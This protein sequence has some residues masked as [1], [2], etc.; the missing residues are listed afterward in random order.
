MERRRDQCIT[1][2]AL[3]R[4]HQPVFRTIMQNRCKK[5]AY[6]FVSLGISKPGC[7]ELGHQESTLDSTQPLW[8]CFSPPGAQYE[9]DLEFMMVHTLFLL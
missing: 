6:I 7:M 2:P 4:L 9:G 8:L 3:P 5:Q 1:D